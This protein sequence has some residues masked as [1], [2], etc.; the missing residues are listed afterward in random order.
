MRSLSQRGGPGTAAL[1]TLQR[2][3]RI[4][5][6]LATKI[7]SIALVVALLVMTVYAGPASGFTNVALSRTG[8]D[9]VGNYFGCGAGN[10]GVASGTSRWEPNTHPIAC[11]GLPSPYT[12]C[13]Y[14]GIF[15][16]ESNGGLLSFDHVTLNAYR[17]GGGYWYVRCNATGPLSDNSTQI[18]S[19]FTAEAAGVTH[20]TLTTPCTNVRYFEVVF[21]GMLDADAFSSTSIYEFEATLETPSIVSASVYIKSLFVSQTSAYVRVS[22]QWAQAYTGTWSAVDNT[23]AVGCGGTF[24]SGTDGALDGTVVAIDPFTSVC[25]AGDVGPLVLTV[26]DTVLNQTASL[27]IPGTARGSVPVGDTIPASP[28]QQPRIDLFIA[29]ISPTTNFCGASPATPVGDGWVKYRVSAD[30]PTATATVRLYPVVNGVTG[31]PVFTDTAVAL[32]GTTSAGVIVTHYLS[33]LAVGLYFLVAENASGSTTNALEFVAGRASEGL[34]PLLPSL[35]EICGPIDPACAVRNA[36]KSIT[37]Q[38]AEL[39]WIERLTSV[40]SLL[41]T[42]ASTSLHDKLVTKQPFATI[43]ASGGVILGQLSRATGAVTTSSTCSGVSI[44]VPLTV[45]TM[46]AP[47]VAGVAMPTPPRAPTSI[48]GMAGRTTG[49]AS[50]TVLDCATF[51]SFTSQWTWWSTVRTFMDVAVYAAYGYGLLLRYDVKFRWSA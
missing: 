21:Y 39:C 44:T 30:D 25:H 13:Y 43:I 18:H 14:W 40:P 31:S 1:S 26:V 15:A 27:T 48:P 50:V 49:P 12:A 41:I 46:T 34:A 24:G 9:S 51:E 11:T 45:T 10:D 47:P 8:C 20:I 16:Q 19:A 36:V 4:S 38:N 23:S 42:D 7:V 35:N 6:R 37:C 28:A 32:N 3:Q 33:P 22:W 17:S 5:R 29:C 2:I